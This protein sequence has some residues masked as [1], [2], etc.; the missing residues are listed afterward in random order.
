MP[1]YIIEHLEPKLWKWC[2]FEYRHISKIVGSKNLWIANIKSEKDTLK[3]RNYAKIIQNSIS[4]LNL[5][6]TCILDPYAKTTLT[7]KIAKKFRFFI[8]GG[9][10]GD[11]PPK[12]RTKKELP[13]K[14]IPRFN[15]GK[16]QMPTDNAVY[17]T[18]QIYDGIPLKQLKF[19]NNLEIR[20]NKIESIILPFKYVLAGNKPLISRQV[21]NYLKRKRTF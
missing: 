20:I 14:N 5:K 1:I 10:L 13:L 11:Y 9:I 4:K 7:P 12:K 18:K 2:L 21:L 15:L 6:H 16:K 3:L 8:F 17:V 19:Q